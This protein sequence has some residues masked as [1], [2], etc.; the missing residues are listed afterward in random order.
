MTAPVLTAR[1][2][3]LVA[4]LHCGLP[5]LAFLL[6]SVSHHAEDLVLFAVD[7]GSQSH[8]HG[9]AQ[10][11]PQR[12]RGNLD[13]RQFEPVRMTLERRAELAQRHHIVKRIKSRDAQAKIKAW[14]FVPGRPDDAVAIRPGWIFRIVVGGIEVKR[15]GNV[16][17]RECAPGV[18]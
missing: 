17:H 4:C 8:A 6:F 3:G 13:T 12:S 5:N 1:R 9:N 10:T 16:H 15:G 14:R 18:P 2:A 7:P 11:L